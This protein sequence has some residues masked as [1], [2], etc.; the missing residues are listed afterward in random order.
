MAEREIASKDPL[1]LLHEE[2]LSLIRVA[3]SYE[4]RSVSARGIR[5]KSDEENGY[6]PVLYWK[7]LYQ[8]EVKL[9]LWISRS[10]AE[11][12]F[13]QRQNA[14]LFATRSDYRFPPNSSDFK[15]DTMPD[16]IADQIY[17]FHPQMITRK[18]K[19]TSSY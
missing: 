7:G 13:D 19:I 16:H 18:G 10:F 1:F 6:P 9:V 8:G 4:C 12:T 3:K 15:I 11:W 5:V 2:N 14:L 17:A